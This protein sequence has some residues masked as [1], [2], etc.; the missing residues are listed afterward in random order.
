M[1]YCSGSPMENYSGVDSRSVADVT[2]AEVLSVLQPIW[3]SKPETASRVLQRM[4]AVFDSAILRGTRERANPC[5]GVT[6]ELG[7]D[8]KRANHHA[9]I[10][11]RAVPEFVRDLR[12]RAANQSTKLALEFLILTAARSGEVR[13]ARWSEFDFGQSLWLI[14]GGDPVTQR[15][16]KTGEPHVVPLAPRA[17]KILEEARTANAAELVFPGTRGQILSDSTFSKLMR[18][19]G[20][21]GTPHGFRS[22]FKDWAAETGVRDE[23]SEAALG[24]SDANRVRAAYRRT[25]FLEERIGVMR[26]W[27]DHVCKSE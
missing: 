24:H 1:D 13:G 27:A 11:W 22:S 25:R 14:P 16:T 9:A 15:R 2:P 8:H 7:T 26:D 17:I 18:E 19:G 20:A 4:K 23:V 12:V 10:P 5:I 3:F 21:A 6:R